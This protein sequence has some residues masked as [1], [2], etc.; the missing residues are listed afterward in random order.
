MMKRTIQW[1]AAACLAALS[2]APALAAGAS[3][4]GQWQV[5][6]GEAR[7]SVAACGD[8]LCAR[9]VWLRA[10]ARTDQNLALLNKYVVRGAQPTATNQWSGDVTFA[11]HSYD[12]TMTMVSR[13]FMTLKGCSGMLC[14][15][16]E[17]TRI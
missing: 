16:Y 1:L 14:Q 3:P 15:T 10:D 5:T 7:Y 11:G 9:L 4:V 6:T 2:T 13:N 12:G 8:A 17:F